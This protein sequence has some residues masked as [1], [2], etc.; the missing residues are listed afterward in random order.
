MPVLAMWRPVIGDLP[1]RMG[2]PSGVP[3]ISWMPRICEKRIPTVQPSWFTVPK[4]PRNVNGAIS[5]TYMGTSEVFRPQLKPMM[6][7]P[8][9]S[10]SYDKN[11][12]EKPINPA[13]TIPVRL[14][15]K[16]PR[17]LF[18]NCSNQFFFFFWGGGGVIVLCFSQELE[19]FYYRNLLTFHRF[20]YH[21]ADSV[22]MK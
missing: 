3:R 21:N 16:S 13:P 7:R 18:K 17:F 4:P 12:L 19:L 2:H 15:S 9:M 1:R 8:M 5:E 11:D 14:F 20:V 22:A 6:N 10:I